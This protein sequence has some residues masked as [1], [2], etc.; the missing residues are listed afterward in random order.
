MLSM[1]VRY[2]LLMGIFKDTPGSRATNIDVC[3]SWGSIK[4][5]KV[6]FYLF[7]AACAFNSYMMNSTTLIMVS[8]ILKIST[9]LK[10]E[11]NTLKD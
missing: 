6:I 1:P 3:T 4:N 7:I 9:R 2:P 5:T 10:C 11:L 8:F